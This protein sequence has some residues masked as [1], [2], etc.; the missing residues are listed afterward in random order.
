MTDT[1]EMADIIISWGPGVDLD[2]M[3]A[4]HFPTDPESR[5]YR[6][7]TIAAKRVAAR[8]AFH[9]MH[10]SELQDEHDRRT[11]KKRERAMKLGAARERYHQQ[12]KRR[13][14]DAAETEIEA[15]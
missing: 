8:A 12:R 11:R 15:S 1:G 6:A 2:A 4:E 3:L 13:T 5:I 9:E 14:E 10:A 7:I